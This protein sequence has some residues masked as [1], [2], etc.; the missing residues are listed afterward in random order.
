MSFMD[1]RH[2]KRLPNEGF[3]LVELL[4]VIAIILFLTGL[5]MP[6][7]QRVRETGKNIKCMNNLRQIAMTTFVYASDYNGFAPG[8]TYAVNAY[9]SFFT[10]WS[11]NPSDG[12]LYKSWYPK[13]KWFAE[14][15]SANKLGEMNPA[16]YCPKGG[17]LGEQGPSVSAGGG[18]SYS[19]ISYGMNPDLFENWWLD[20][21]NPDRCS[22]PLLQIKEPAGVSMWVDSNRNK[23]YAR[24]NCIS[25][26]HFSNSRKV[27]IEPGPVIGKHTVYQYNGKM[28]VIFV[29]GHLVSLKV[30]DEVP[31]WSCRF[32]D[33][34]RAPKCKPG[35]CGFCDKD[36]RH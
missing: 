25:G 13:N 32:W 8:D 2:M 19:N 4:V 9:D 20:N 17:R 33:H 11:R 23:T 1:T 30:P 26:R 5:L 18:V 24:G 6:T 21:Q 15:F 36:V 3:T 14:Y 7:L 27:A 16:A 12:K 28:N 31:M 35:N 29:D 10:P 22:V 34:S